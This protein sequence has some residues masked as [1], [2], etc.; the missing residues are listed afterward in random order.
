[1][2]ARRMVFLGLVAFLAL[3]LISG[4]R[5][6][7]GEPAVVPQW[8]P[9]VKHATLVGFDEAGTHITEIWLREKPAGSS[10]TNRTVV[11]AHEGDQ[12]TIL[13]QRADG[14]VKVRTARGA[15]GWTQID[16]LKD[17]R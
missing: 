15:E 16:A 14:T 10:G 5:M 11:T 6:G 12:V 7:G 2:T 13:E 9:P 8:A 1:M 3:L 17:I 4:A